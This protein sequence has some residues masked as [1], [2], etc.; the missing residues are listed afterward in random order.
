MPEEEAVR[1]AREGSGMEGMDYVREVTTESAYPWDP[2]DKLS[3]IWTIVK[4]ETGEGMEIEPNGEAFR[5]LPPVEHRIVALDFGIKHNILRNLRQEGFGVTVMP[6][7]ATAEEV[8]ALK[9]AGVFLSNGPGDPG[10]LEYAHQTVRELIG[11]TPIFGI[12]LGHQL[13][14]YACGGRTYKLKFG[15]HG[16][17]QPVKDLQT[18]KVTI[19]AQNHGF[20]VD[21]ESLPC[22][23]GGHARESK[24]RHR[25]GH[26]PQG[27]ARFQRAIPSR[28]GARAARRQLLL[29]ASSAN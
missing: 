14:G 17:N 11:R 9:P 28:G 18:G 20:A 16:G 13:L 26:A 12:C 23:C 10:A 24:R 21:P 3:R 6:A 19:T 27:C 5:K 8:M 1:R 7:T 25:G 2:S 22:A 4:G 15:H 29:S